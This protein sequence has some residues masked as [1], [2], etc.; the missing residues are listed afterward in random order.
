LTITEGDG[1]IFERENLGE[2]ILNY[3]DPAAFYGNCSRNTNDK[4]FLWDEISNIDSEIK[5]FEVPHN[6]VDAQI[7]IYTRVMIGTILASLFILLIYNSTV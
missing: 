3:M 1:L 4:L 6:I 7:M 2:S 5:Q